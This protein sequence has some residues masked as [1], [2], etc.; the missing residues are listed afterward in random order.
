MQISTSL[1]QRCASKLSIL[2]EENTWLLSPSQQAAY[3]VAIVPFVAEACA[4]TVL[5]RIIRSYHADHHEVEILQT[6]HHP[7]HDMAWMSWR[8]QI[9]PILNYAGVLRS[10]DR[11]TEQDDIIQ[12]A[13]VELARALPT[14]R[15][16]SRLSSW[17]YMVVV[18]RTRRAIRDSQAQ[19]RQAVLLPIDHPTALGVYAPSAIQPD[20]QIIMQAL[21]ETIQEILAAH[22]G[23]R[24]ARVFHLWA[25]DDQ[26]LVD[27]GRRTRL[28]PARISLL[29]DEAR[30][31]LRLHEEIQRWHMSMDAPGT[32]EGSGRAPKPNL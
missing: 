19:K 29:L 24:L 27:I 2:N 14:Y 26:R 18:Q 22:G 21:V 25:V 23:E 4:D 20:V 12:L 6:H 16:Q 1:P 28:S 15:F 30:Q 13:L 7:K 32:M 9:G 10:T 5:E 3:I 31:V 11:S 8:E 17:A